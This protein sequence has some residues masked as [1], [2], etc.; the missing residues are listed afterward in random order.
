MV[1][2]SSTIALPE[3]YAITAHIANGGMASVWAAE[4]RTLGR[5]VAIKVLAPH[6][7]ADA[8][9][10][11]RF[12]REGRAAARLSSHPHVVT[13]FDVGEHDGRAFIVMERARGG[14]VA[15]ALRAGPVAP[16]AALRWLREA[17]GALDAAHAQGI[18]HRDVKP[19]NLL[20]DEHGRVLVADFG[21]ARLATE[22]TVTATGQVL[23]SAA[24][25]S[26][27]QALGRPATPASDVYALSVVAYELL[28]GAR[29]FAGPS[30]AAQ[31]RQHVESEA[32]AASARAPGLPPALDAVLRRGLAKDPAGRWPTAAGLVDALDEALGAPAPDGQTQATR[33]LP[34]T[35]AKLRRRPLVPLA[36][37]TVAGIVGLLVAL[38]L[39]GG[40]PS[41]RT[42]GVR[43]TPSAGP[44]HQL[45]PAAPPATSSTGTTASTTSERAG[46]PATAAALEARGHALLEQGAVNEAIPILQRAVALSGQTLAGCLEPAT[47]PCLTYAFA[48][49]DLGHGLR[50][51]GRPTEAIPILER[52]LQIDNQRG[53]VRREL[54]LALAQAGGEPAPPSPGE[55]GGK[56]RGGKK[57]HGHGGDQGD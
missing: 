31:A 19:A 36:L 50:L 6:Y 13:I 44:R 10:R 7:A 15:E 33:P 21:I 49:Y 34:L 8:A 40:P 3:R 57:G 39:S 9:S 17:A 38:A 32:V 52:R 35:V 46:S 56:G 28:T 11:R 20:L 23:G 54:D 14:T 55:H 24:Y 47:S 42:L 53:A 27:E 18:V 30:F 37:A 12:E 4:D 2:L 5:E 26:P 22:D 45:P 51:A 48:L 25:L 1:E 16:E 29:P 43:R 41:A